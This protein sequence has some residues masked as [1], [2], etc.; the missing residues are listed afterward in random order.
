[1]FLPPGFVK[2]SCHFNYLC[3]KFTEMVYSNFH[4]HTH[5]SDGKKEPSL[6]CQKA[7][8]LGFHSLGFSDHAPVPFPS[9]YSIPEEKL[10]S[11]FENIN[12]LKNE[13]QHQLQIFLSLEAD[14]IP[15]H[16]F[17]FNYFRQKA[18]LDYLIGS[19]H[20][21]YHQSKDQMWFIDG[22][23]QDVW[24]KGLN[25][26]FDMDIKMA[27][28]AFF[29][30]S[31]QMIEEEKPDVIAHPDKIKMHN[32]E[33]F[34]SQNDKWYQNLINEMLELIRQKD[35][36]MEINTRGLYKGRCQS[37]FPSQSMILKAE[38]M[39]VPMVLSSDAHHPDELT[40][41]FPQAL[42]ILNKM[43]VGNIY[44]FSTQGWKAISL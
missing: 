43:G 23:K 38:K 16:S 34:F 42:D 13:Y 30:Q 20:M 14:F 44:E 39:G 15:H 18:H 37:L 22:G 6:Y 36:I 4:T 12:L 10:M 3:P 7:L 17:S 31:N 29:Y 9:N 26:I 11:Y 24:D 21:V 40:S 27:V 19:V 33:R 1:M 28:K 35:I 25:E 41:A 2:N 32:K 8:E 5:F